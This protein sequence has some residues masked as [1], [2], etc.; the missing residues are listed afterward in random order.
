[1]NPEPLDLAGANALHEAGKLHG[2]F[3]M[4]DH[5]YR[6]A[7]GLNQS[8]LKIMQRSPAHCK[9]GEKKKPTKALDMGTLIHLLLLEGKEEF[10]KVCVPM[11][12][13]NPRTK[14]FRDRKQELLDQGKI[15]L[16]GPEL[17]VVIGIWKQSQDDPLV[18]RVIG[19]GISEVVAFARHPEGALMKGKLDKVLPEEKIIGDLKTTSNADEQPFTM[20]ARKY[21]YD[22][23]AAYYLDL[24]NLAMGSEHFRRFVILAADKTPPYLFNYFFIDDRDIDE[25]RIDYQNC[26]K[27]W[28]ECES[29]G[30]W[31]GYEPKFKPLRIRR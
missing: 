14:V 21:Q 15:L 13:G 23:Q 9:N 12:D 25:A 24:I 26:M 4:S 16:S 7:P 19:S 22:F 11:P 27:L 6:L 5:D 17:D 31:P 20:S 3:Y 10:D 1:M 28:L 8:M 29:S 18:Q 2:L 30:H